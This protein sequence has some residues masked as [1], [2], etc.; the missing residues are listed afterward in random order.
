M[1]QA[2]IT[3]QGNHLPI[4]QIQLTPLCRFCK[5]GHNPALVFLHEIP[6]LTIACGLGRP[7]ENLSVFA[8][9][10][11]QRFP[12]TLDHAILHGI[13][14]STVFFIFQDILDFSHEK[15]IIFAMKS[16]ILP[17]FIP[18]FER[19]Y[20]FDVPSSKSILNRALLLAA[21]T[22][23]DTMIKCGSFGEDTQAILSCL[24]TLGIKIET[25]KEG[26]LVHGCGQN[27]PCKEANLNV[28]SAG[29]CA[30][31]LPAILA[32]IGGN[33][34]FDSS[35]QMKKRP[36]DF[37]N[38][39]ELAGVKIEYLEKRNHFPFRLISKGFQSNQ[40]AIDTE[41]STQYASA[42]LIAGALKDTPLEVQL[43]GSRTRGS[44]IQMTLSLL[45]A[46]GASCKRE[47]DVLT[48]HR[49]KAA[50]QE[51]E[52]EA[53]ISAACYFYALALLFGIKVLVR[54]VKKN[55]L[56][57]DIKF[58]H[59]LEARGVT[60]TQTD[61]GLLAD[62]SNVSSFAGFQENLKDYSDQALT[63]AALAPYAASPSRLTGIGHIRKQECDRI[64]A[65]E[66]N[67]NALG[68]PCKAGE[69]EVGIYP[70]PPKSGKIQTFHD[71]R[72]AMAF[73]LVALKT[74]G[75]EIDDAQCCAKTFQEYFDEL[76]QLFN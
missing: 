10:K 18:D 68:V 41:V 74:G 16:I 23:G 61:E 46:F 34:F 53:D 24:S 9:G 1:Y 49:T 55:S 48:V 44:Y 35:E 70:T 29:T 62:G 39:L 19:I 73:A 54:R 27:I 59:L 14:Y 67:L 66:E 26:L 51:F 36:M 76:N 45:D 57:G 50:P 17:R 8:Y 28:M 7:N 11:A 21:F 63:V 5:L 15:I 31:F 56:Q 60:F 42:L 2:G 6:N 22:E 47:N 71:H 3:E 38:V 33:Y 69:N 72:V 20:S 30:R 65:I 37:L 12:L 58:L 43:S 4:A 52:A 40:F 13:Y 32:A 25:N 75:V 64:A